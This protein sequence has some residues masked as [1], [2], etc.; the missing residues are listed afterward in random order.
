MK[1]I[2]INVHLDPIKQAKD[3]F[4]CDLRM[5]AEKF[6]L[7]EYCTIHMMYEESKSWAIV[8]GAALFI[9]GINRAGVV[10]T[11]EVKWYNAYS[12]ED[13]ANQHFNLGDTLK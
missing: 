10:T 2:K 12:A 5:V 11:G 8:T 1:V 13:G 9:P 3:I 6:E 7:F 4:N